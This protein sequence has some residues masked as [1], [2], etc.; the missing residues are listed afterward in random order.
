M[1]NVEGDAA[2]ISDLADCEALLRRLHSQKLIHGD[3]NRYNFI[4]NRGSGEIRL[5]DFEHVMDFDEGLAREELLSLPEELTEETGR[6]TTVEV[7]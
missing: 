3:V 4:V 2:C 6:G 5:V 1:E 7:Q